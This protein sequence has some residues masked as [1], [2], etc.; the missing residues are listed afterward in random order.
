MPWTATGSKTSRS[1]LKLLGAQ[2]QSRTLLRANPLRLVS[3]TQPG[4]NNF[5]RIAIAFGSS[6]FKPYFIRK[7]IMAM[8]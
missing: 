4:S 7:R 2:E 6:F 8:L 5:H 3:A 1:A